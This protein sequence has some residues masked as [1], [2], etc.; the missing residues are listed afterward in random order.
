MDF[1][2]L[3]LAAR[4]ATPERVAKLAAFVPAGV[5]P[6]SALFESESLKTNVEDAEG[7]EIDFR[8]TVII[9]TSNIGSELV[10]RAVEHGVKE[11][12]KTRQPTAGDLVEILRPTLQKAFKPAFLG[13]LLG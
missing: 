12:E 13:R 2:R 6:P 11:G 1:A 5:V 10:M 3:R 8:N 9:L 7:R 4:F